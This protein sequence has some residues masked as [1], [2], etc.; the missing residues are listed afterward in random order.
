M[1]SFIRAQIKK[2]SKLRVTGLCAGNSP[3]TDE[4]PTQKASNAE[5]VSILWRHHVAIVNIDCSF[6]QTILASNYW[7]AQIFIQHD[8]LLHGSLKA[9][10]FPRQDYDHMWLILFNITAFMY[11]IDAFL[12][13]DFPF[14][15]G[16]EQSWDWPMS[17]GHPL[18]KCVYN[19][20]IR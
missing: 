4:F 11:S 5:N 14:V 15:T 3:V 18:G 9:V 13:L 1:Q 12:C 16:I 6:N 8:C 19:Y 17:L 2:I 20:I 7:H 10:D